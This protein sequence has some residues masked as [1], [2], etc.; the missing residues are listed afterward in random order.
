MSLFPELKRHSASQLNSFI[1]YRADWFL[2][3]IRGIR[4]GVGVHAYRGTAVE[5]GMNHFIENE[6]S[7]EECVKHA[8]AVYAQESIGSPDNFD[9]R[10]S[11]GPATIAGIKS[12]EEKGYFI[13]PPVLQAEIS[14]L[15]PGCRVQ[16][17][18]KLD[19]DFDNIII[20][21]KVVGKTPSSL[22]QDYI[23]QGAVYRY[24]TG[25]DVKFHFVIPQKKG[26]G[27]KE[28]QLTDKEYDFGLQL[29]SK[30]AQCIERIYDNL[31]NLDGELLESLFFTNPSALYDPKAK[32]L[33][34]EQFGIDIP[35]ENISE[36]D[37]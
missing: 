14:C 8:F 27:I 5:A 33:H 12:F 34:S 22:K 35:M 24:A 10:Q 19:Y 31:A 2:Q 18:G 21:N 7:V 16:L 37:D 17:Y 4:T 11:V 1:G 29:A 25:K 23:L 13:D 3:R 9:I 30:A 6:V 28:I 20:D 32:K 26:I 36:G 15:L